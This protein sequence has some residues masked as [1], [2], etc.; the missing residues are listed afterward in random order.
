MKWRWLRDGPVFVLSEFRE[1]L[2]GILVAEATHRFSRYCLGRER[3][4][5][6]LIESSAAMLP[7]ELMLATVLIVLVMLVAHR[8]GDK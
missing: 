4:V 6:R 5:R 3:Y 8:V 1:F 7:Y 2:L